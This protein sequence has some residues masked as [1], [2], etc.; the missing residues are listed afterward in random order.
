MIDKVIHGASW[1]SQLTLLRSACTAFVRCEIRVPDVSFTFGTKVLAA[2]PGV[3][4][5]FPNKEREEV[6]LEVVVRDKQALDETVMSTIQ[7]YWPVVKATRTLITVNNMQWHRDSM[8]AD[9][10]VFIGTAAP[11][12]SWAVMLKDHLLRDVGVECWLYSNGIPIGEASWPDSVDEA[13]KSAP[14]YI[15]LISDNKSDELQREIGQAEG[16]GRPHDICPLVLP[17]TS[18]DDIAPRLKLKQDLDA[19]DFFAYSKMLDWIGER[20]GRPDSV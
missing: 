11:D 18:F 17:G 5:V 14:L 12:L 6:V 9:S 1:G 16:V 15:F 3:T 2:I 4:R 7:G 20:L 13:I 19:N 8:Q 10:R